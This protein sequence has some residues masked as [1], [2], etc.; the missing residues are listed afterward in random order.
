[1]K[2]TN[3][4]PEVEVIV[5]LIGILELEDLHFAELQNYTANV[6]GRLSAI[7]TD[8]DISLFSDGGHPYMTS[9][10]GGGGQ[11]NLILQVKG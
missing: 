3:V 9:D 7:F 1:M 11:P 4:P 6:F 5:T 10:G 2:I 8:K